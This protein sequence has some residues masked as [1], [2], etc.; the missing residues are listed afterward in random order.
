MQASSK[1][2]NGTTMALKQG[3]TVQRDISKAD[4]HSRMSI[5]YELMSIVNALEGH[6]IR[7]TRIT[8]S[9]KPVVFHPSFD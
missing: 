1:S 7:E 3:Q 6:I 9:E 4:R 5:V 8:F 2:A